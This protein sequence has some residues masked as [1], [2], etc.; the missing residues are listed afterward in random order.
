MVINMRRAV[1]LLPVYV[2]LMVGVDVVFK[3]V[4]L[5]RNA[6]VPVWLAIGFSVMALAFFFIAAW[7]VVKARGQVPV[8]RERT[9]L[10]LIV[11]VMVSG[12]VDD[13]LN[14]LAAMIFHGRSAWLS[15]P[16]SVLSY[17]VLLVVLVSILNSGW[18]RQARR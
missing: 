16:V 13:G 6:A 9:Y 5:D 14:G 3:S 18:V 10:G 1:L 17:V 4:G 8:D 11:A 15:I 2:A 7:F 12:F